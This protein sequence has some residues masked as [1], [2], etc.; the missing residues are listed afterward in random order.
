MALAARLA[1]VELHQH[2]VIDIRAECFLNG[3]QIRLVAI[4]GQLN[5]V[6]QPTAKIV[7][8]H[9]GELRITAP[10]H[11]R[12]QQLAVGFDRG[13][14]PA[15]ADRRIAGAFAGRRVLLLGVNEAPNLVA[16][17]AARLHTAHVLVVVFER[18]FAGLAQQLVHCV[19]GAADRPLDRPHGHAL[20][21]EREDLGALGE[22]QLVHAPIV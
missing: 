13:P 11:V 3:A 10:D 9:Q 2:P 5:P 21:Q 8:Q 16:L 1:A 4:R 17:D 14:G 20:T 22:G 18:S 7:H 15:I 19:D 6:R 12:D